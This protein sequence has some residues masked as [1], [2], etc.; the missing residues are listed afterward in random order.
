M[1][2]KTSPYFILYIL[3]FQER[4]YPD[5]Y[6]QM[7]WCEINGLFTFPVTGKIIWRRKSKYGNLH[8]KG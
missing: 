3:G 5:A 1:K 4:G 8:F 6:F 7:D 2:M